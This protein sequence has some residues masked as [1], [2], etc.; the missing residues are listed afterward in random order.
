MK[1]RTTAYRPNDFSVAE[2]RKHFVLFEF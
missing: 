2:R 1:L